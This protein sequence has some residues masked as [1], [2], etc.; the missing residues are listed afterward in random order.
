MPSLIDEYTGTKG[1][2]LLNSLG[3]AGGNV[4]KTA[5]VDAGRSLVDEVGARIGVAVPKLGPEGAASLNV[6]R[7]AGTGN[8]EAPNARNT[9]Q[10]KGGLMD[11][12]MAYWK[13]IAV[14]AVVIGLVLFFKRK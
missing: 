11:T 8:V 6:P 3:T 1:A 2:D 10:S 7:G 12:V 5:A 9:V 13:P 4:L 14:I